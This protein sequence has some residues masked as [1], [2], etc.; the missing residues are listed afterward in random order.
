MSA[1]TRSQSDAVWSASGTLLP[2]ARA[3]YFSAINRRLFIL[4]DPPTDD[5]VVE[6]ITASLTDGDNPS[7]TC[8]EGS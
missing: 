4:R 1:L 3:A 7:L 2:S 5:E 6:A 8:N